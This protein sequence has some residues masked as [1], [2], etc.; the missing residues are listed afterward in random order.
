[1]FSL[2]ISLKVNIVTCRRKALPFSRGGRFWGQI[3]TMW[4]TCQNSN[5]G[6]LFLPARWALLPPETL[7]HISGLLTALVSL[8]ISRMYTMCSGVL[9][10]CTY[11]TMWVY[12]IYENVKVTK[13]TIS[14]YVC[15]IHTYTFC[16]HID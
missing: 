10:L 1:M 9:H 7:V 15:I 13:W 14:I 8:C 3:F 16:I 6:N 5:Q 12:R 4:I 11:V 2:K